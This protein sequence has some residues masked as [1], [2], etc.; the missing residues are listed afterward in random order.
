[1]QIEYLE[2][3]QELEARTLPL[4]KREQLKEYA[5]AAGDFNPIHLSD[6]DAKDIGLPGVIAH[7]MLTM[8]TTGLLFSP[9]LDRGFIKCF[10]TRFAGRVFPEDAITIGA[11]LVDRE[12]IEQGN[13]YHFEVF[14]NNQDDNLVAT[15]KVAFCVHKSRKAPHQKPGTG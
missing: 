6:D 8:A 4:L 9:Y 5:E 2:V 15:G 12:T 7:G 14:A 11:K 13:V 10:E 3:G 1:M